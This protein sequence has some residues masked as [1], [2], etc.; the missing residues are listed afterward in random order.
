[1]GVQ[2]GQRITIRLGAVILGARAL[3]DEADRLPA[4]RLPTPWRQFDLPA[5]LGWRY[6]EA[7]QELALGPVLGIMSVTKKGSPHKYAG[8][9]ELFQALSKRGRE[10][11]MLVYVFAPQGVNWPSHKV[12]GVL[13]GKTRTAGVFPLPDVVF[14]RVPHRSYEAWAAVAEVKSIMRRWER[15]GRP[16]CQLFNPGFFDKWDLYEM[17]RDNPALKPHLPVTELCGGKASLKAFAAERPRVFLKPVDGHA[18]LGTYLLERGSSSY[19]LRH[20]AKDKNVTLSGTFD[21]TFAELEPQ[22]RKTRYLMQPA[23]PLAKADG[24]TFDCRLLLQKDGTGTWRITGSGARVAGK[25]SITT[26]VPAGGH[27]ADLGEVLKQAVRH[28]LETRDNVHALALATAQAIET[29]LGQRVGEMSMDIG[30]DKD[31]NL[32]F[33]EANAKPMR[34]DEPRIRNLSYERLLSYVRF[35]A[36][37]EGGEQ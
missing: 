25:G 30:V 16:G 14:N 36:G 23:V 37:F 17:L 31:E 33:F 12:D 2:N 19:R 20:R 4:L 26:H 1:L 6:D 29:A 13:Y 11:G 28:P 8:N 34:F 22:L 18:G 5:E 7:K 24:S 9:H 21:E 35:L 32:W 3:V 10:Q 27:I 15:S